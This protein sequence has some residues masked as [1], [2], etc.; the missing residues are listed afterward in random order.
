MQTLSIK[1][2]ALVLA[3][4]IFA[5]SAMAADAQSPLPGSQ[6]AVAANTNQCDPACVAPEIC[7]RLSGTESACVDPKDCFS[8]DDNSKLKRK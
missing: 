8:S 1:F 2:I 3:A 7:C 6:S 4:P 5:A